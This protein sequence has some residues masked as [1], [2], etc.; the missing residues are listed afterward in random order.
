M[1][2]HTTGARKKER[3]REIPTSIDNAH[4]SMYAYGYAPSVPGERAQVDSR[5]Q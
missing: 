4:P 3:E 1:T 5:V 2:G